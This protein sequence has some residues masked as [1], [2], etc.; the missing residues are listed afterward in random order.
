MVMESNDWRL[1]GQEKYL[2][3]AKFVFK[4]FRVPSEQWDHEHCEFCSKK[5]SEYEGD[6]HQGYYTAETDF[7]VCPDCFKDFKDMFQ[8]EVVDKVE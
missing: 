7:W 1:Q 3:K 8:W 5:F 2:T 4:D 6:L